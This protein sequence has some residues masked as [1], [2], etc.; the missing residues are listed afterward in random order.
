MT[1]LIIDALIALTTLTDRTC[2]A[3]DNVLR[4]PV[5]PRQATK[6]SP[7]GAGRADRAGSGGHPVRTTSEL[8][9]GAAGQLLWIY[10]DK[11]PAVIRE[12]VEDLI[13]RAAQ[14]RAAGD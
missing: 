8:L 10:D 9:G 4:R 13:D 14:F 11:A 7:A 12:L 5:T 1:G 3:V 6:R 2:T